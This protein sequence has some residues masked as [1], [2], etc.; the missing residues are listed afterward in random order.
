MWLS[1][2]RPGATFV[3]LLV[4]L[5][6]LVTCERELTRKLNGRFVRVS[7]ITNLFCWGNWQPWIISY[8]RT[9][10]QSQ[11]WFYAEEYFYNILLNVITMNAFHIFHKLLCILPEGK[12]IKFPDL[13]AF[14]RTSA[15]APFDFRVKEQT[16]STGVCIFVSQKANIQSEC[17][18]WWR[19]ETSQHTR[20]DQHHLVSIF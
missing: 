2:Y 16:S 15:S 9:F 3:K 7:Q 20:R 19:H 11:M 5:K 14:F 13:I 6:I 10:D 12:L 17:S 18:H 8:V 1:R 4:K